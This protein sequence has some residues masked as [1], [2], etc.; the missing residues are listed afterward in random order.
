MNILRKQ[1][2]C[3]SSL[4]ALAA[5]V[6]VHTQAAVVDSGGGNSSGTPYYQSWAWSGT[7]DGTDNNRLTPQEGQTFESNTGRTALAVNNT[8]NHNGATITAAESTTPGG[9]FTSR[10]S[11]S[12]SITNANANDGYYSLAGYG[13]VTS[14]QFFTPQAL[15]DHARFNWHVS[16][17]ESAPVMGQ[18]N[19][20]AQMFDNCHTSRLDFLA[21]T[22]TSLS[23]GD[24]FNPA[25]NPYTQFGAGNFSYDISG[26]PLNQQ[27]NLMY[28][29]SAFVQIL[30]GQ[31]AQGGS[32]SAFADY[33]NT[34]D[35]MSIDLFDANNNLITDWT[36]MDPATGATVFN[37]GGRVPD[38][39]PEPGT[40]ALLAL[41]LFG[42][43]TV[44]RI[45]QT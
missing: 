10:N 8:Y 12:I 11:A 13:S 5:V 19:P 42:L 23:F 45:R 3:S 36:L 30:P 20:T 17:I 26:L 25:N 6:S 7:F 44:R 37:Q 4:I 39:V 1:R 34:Y 31:I 28:W 2:L 18:C 9:F 21:T 33:S 41:S 35:L 32:F 40:L 43:G 38:S 16:G 15:A 14:V 29:T 24:L 27:I 22:N